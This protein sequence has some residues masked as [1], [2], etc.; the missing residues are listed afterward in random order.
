MGNNDMCGEN[1]YM[2]FANIIVDGIKIY[3]PRD[4]IY[5]V[6]HNPAL[7]MADLAK[8]ELIKTEWKFDKEFWDNIARLANFCDDIVIDELN[9]KKGIK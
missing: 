4:E 6:S 3:D 7:V 9:K 8:R 1:Q 5:K 2:T